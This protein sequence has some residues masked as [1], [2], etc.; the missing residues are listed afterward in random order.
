MLD[1]ARFPLAQLHRA[2]QMYY[3]EDRTQAQIA[4]ALSVSRPTV[5]RLLAESRRI[6]LV[7]IQV[8]DPFAED[9]TALAARLATALGLDRC[10]LAQS[11]DP[12]SPWPAIAAPLEAVFHDLNLSP[13]DVV[14]TASG[15]MTYAVGRGDLPQHVGTIVVPTVGGQNEPEPWHQANE[16]ARSWAERLGG[17]PAFIYAPALPSAAM[18]DLLMQDSEYLRIE[19]LWGQ[20]KAAFVGVGAPPSQRTS[21]SRAINTGDAGLGSARGDVCL[22]FFDQHGEPVEFTNSDRMIRI[23]LGILKAIPFTIALAAGDDKVESIVG[24][25]RGGYIRRL[26]TDAPTAR[27]LLQLLGA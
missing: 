12:R 13:G 15:Q 21:I 4:D 26:V 14:V 8:L 7:S 5:S 22:H 2:A 27:S 9:L 3:L 20:A 24:A 23:P 18:H 1:D 11:M 10:Y 6:G 17:R 19:R 16:I 25:S